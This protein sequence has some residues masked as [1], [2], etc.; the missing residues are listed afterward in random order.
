MRDERECV[1]CGTHYSYCPNCVQY[2]SEPRWKFLFHDKNC[3]DIYNVLN[4]YGSNVISKEQAR[5]K[6]KTLDLTNIKSFRQDFRNQV[7]DI[8][9]QDETKVSKPKQNSTKMKAKR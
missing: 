1:I 9:K 7:N 3:H 6:L 2:N 5:N 8:L 4:D